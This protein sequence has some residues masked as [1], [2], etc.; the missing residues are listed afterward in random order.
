MTIMS[1]HTVLT[2]ARRGK[3]KIVFD[4]SPHKLMLM[5]EPDVANGDIRPTDVYFAITHEV[6]TKQISGIKVSCEDPDKITVVL[7]TFSYMNVSPLEDL[8]GEVM[9]EFNVVGLIGNLVQKITKPK[10]V[11]TRSFARNEPHNF[12]LPIT[13]KL[14]RL[15]I[16]HD[17][18]DDKTRIKIATD[19]EE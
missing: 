13:G 8:K 18:W 1:D 9:R 7:S 15:E 4:F 11:E 2:M 12:R 5:S 3:Q 6:E 17:R 19:M 14:D 10:S 16:S